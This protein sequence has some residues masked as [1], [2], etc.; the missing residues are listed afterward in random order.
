MEI[1]KSKAKK[2][3]SASTLTALLKPENETVISFPTMFI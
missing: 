1:K 3:I 2:A